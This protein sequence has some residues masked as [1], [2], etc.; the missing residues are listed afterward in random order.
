MKRNLRLLVF[1]TISCLMFIQ[2]HK[3]ECKSEYLGDLRFTETDL[4]INPYTGKER[5]VFKDSIGDSLCY[6]CEGRLSSSN[7]YIYEHYD[8]ES[9][10][11]SKGDYYKLEFNQTYFD[12]PAIYSGITVSIGIGNPF[13]ETK[14]YIGINVSYQ[15]TKTWLFECNFYFD[16][17]ALFDV[18]PPPSYAYDPG[19]HILIFDDSI[20]VGHHLHYSV[21]TLVQTNG[22]P[23]SSLSNLK[24]VYYSIKEG[25]VGFK[26]DEGH[27]WFLA[28]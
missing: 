8:P 23:M 28:N 25:I 22:P 27:L 19:G 13:L 21:Y 12:E 16:S 5:L 26:T 17:L 24:T 18:P 6:N 11:G 10:N 20:I 1:V 14:N 3:N 15:D 7:H 4:K 9:Y 2:C